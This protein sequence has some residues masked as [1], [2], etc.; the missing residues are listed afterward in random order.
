MRDADYQVF[1]P[2]ILA[3]V[4]L[5]L[6]FQNAEDAAWVERAIVELKRDRN[7]TRLMGGILRDSLLKIAHAP[8]VTVDGKPISREDLNSLRCNGRRSD[9]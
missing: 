3:P 2:G 4:K 5:T 9:S 7:Q 6:E 1:N 8:Q